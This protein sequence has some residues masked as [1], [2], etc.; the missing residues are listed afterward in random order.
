M[1]VYRRV[2][3]LRL[4]LLLL[5]LLLLKILSLLLLLQS[6]GWTD[7]QQ[8]DCQQHISIEKKFRLKIVIDYLGIVS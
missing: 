7:H 4:L 2:L 8:K 6:G 5:S 3:L 1:F